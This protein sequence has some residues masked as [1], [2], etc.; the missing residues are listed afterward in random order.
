MSIIHFWIAQSAVEEDPL[1]KIG[2]TIENLHARMRSE[3][4][5]VSKAYL[6]LVHTL[7]EI[8]E[9]SLMYAMHQIWIKLP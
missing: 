3:T 8:D 4:A 7:M 1:A 2:N 9:H 5:A 6:N